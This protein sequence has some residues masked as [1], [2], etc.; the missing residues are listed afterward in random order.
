MISAENANAAPVN[1][2][3]YADAAALDS[4]IPSTY[5]EAAADH[6][7]T[8]GPTFDL[9]HTANGGHV[10]TPPRTVSPLPTP[11]EYEGAGLDESPKTPTK[12]VRPLSRNGN[13]SGSLRQAF[14]E[15]EKKKHSDTIVYEKLA[16]SNGHGHLT[17][18]KPE[19]DYDEALRLDKTEARRT[20]D[21]DLVLK[22]G[23]IPSA[24]WEQSGFVMFSF[25]GL[26]LLTFSV[27]FAGLH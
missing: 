1:G 17:S 12:R 10:I 4:Q 18:V 20:P 8:P 14:M 26:L 13:L 11:G 25:L 22:S 19:D 2:V 3:S 9:T 6:S 27:A 15:D 23:R 16:H 21:G 5:A 7:K 24:G